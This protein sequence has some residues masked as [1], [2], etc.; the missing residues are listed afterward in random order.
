[1]NSIYSKI[2]L[3]LYLVFLNTLL[4]NN[5]SVF[6]QQ[7]PVVSTSSWSIRNL[8][9]SVSCQTENPQNIFQILFENGLIPDPF[10]GTNEQKV[11]WV[12]EDDWIF[13]TH[14][15]VDPATLYYKHISIYFESLDTY[16]EVFLNG[17][18]IGTFENMFLDNNFAIKKLL[19]AKNNHLKI[20]FYSAKK[21][22]LALQKAYGIKLPGEERV[23]IRKPQYH[24]GWDWG[25]TLTGC[26]ITSTPV[27]KAYNEVEL[28]SVFVVADQDLPEQNTKLHLDIS[29]TLERSFQVNCQIG[30]HFLDTLLFLSPG[31]HTYTLSVHIDQPQLWWTHNLGEPFLYEYNIQGYSD[32]DKFAISGKF[33]FRKVVLHTQ[34]DS[35]GQDFYFTLN[36]KRVFAKGANYIPTNIMGQREESLDPVSAVQEAR[37]ANM[38]ML[39]VW[40]GGIYESDAFYD[41]CD[42]LGIMVWQ[43]FMF[44]CG[45]YP[46]DQ[47][48]LNSVKEEATF[49]I[50][51]LR[52][53]PSM[54][55]YCGNNENNEAWHRWGWKPSFTPSQQTKIWQDYQK[56]FNNIL[57][58]LVQ[59]HHPDISY[60]ESSPKFGRG[61]TRYLREGDAHDWWVWHDGRPFR[62]FLTAVPR[63]MS[64]FGFQSFPDIQT[65][66]TF[67]DPSEYDLNHPTML[68]H[69]KHPKGNAIIKDFTERDYPKP[70]NFE[71]FV[72]LSQM[73]QADGMALGIETHL[74]NQPYCSGSLYWQLN[75]CWP[76]ASWSSMDYTGRWKPMMYQVKHLFAPSII[77]CYMSDDWVLHIH[78][79]QDNSS[80]KSLQLTAQYMDFNGTPLRVWQEQFA[81]NQP[82]KH[83]LDIDLKL[84]KEEFHPNE[85]VFYL[86]VQDEKGHLLAEK[87]HFVLSPKHLSL[88]KPT[89][90]L[91]KERIDERYILTLNTQSLA[92][93]VA[94]QASADGTWS[95]NFFDLIPGISKQ[96]EFFPKEKYVPN[97]DFQAKSM[98]DFIQKD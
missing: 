62:H 44:A 57:P 43:D 55:L 51:R 16:G 10:V 72:Y 74:R 66:S 53:H 59:A 14:F 60:W 95:D 7:S 81:S 42:S 24:F 29:S 35:S 92:K 21:K 26:G 22:A 32:H 5:Y 76:V 83:V 9:N 11:Q 77:S 39:R 50:K 67:A 61:D 49:Q 36:G 23:F 63:F 79:V 78:W 38:N 4:M 18:K 64:E 93:N 97:I 47:N 37:F 90:Q 12:A 6:G 65:I 27:I 15:D 1:M 82:S 89:I 86:S 2:F 69:Q 30:D 71:G 48:F 80:S 8:K 56:L 52:N 96:V 3:A 73:V 13:D 33:G 45:M 94:L 41:A 25:P 31:L 91:A 17:T 88:S 34:Q 40:G 54:A 70:K 19:Q 87:I 46:G 84:F 28:K 58:N 20:L 98:I 75:D 85:H 68:Q